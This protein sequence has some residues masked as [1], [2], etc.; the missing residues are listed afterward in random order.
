MMLKEEWPAIVMGA[1]RGIGQEY[2]LG[3]AREGAKAVM[4]DVLSCEE[5]APGCSE[6]GARY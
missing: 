4:T 3:L 1:A 2:S 5:T 6:A